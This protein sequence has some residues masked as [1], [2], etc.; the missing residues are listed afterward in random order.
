MSSTLFLV[1]QLRN[2]LLRMIT[3]ACVASAPKCPWVVCKSLQCFRCGLSKSYHVLLCS[4]WHFWIFYYKQYKL[5]FAAPFH[6]SETTNFLYFTV[7]SFSIYPG[8]IYSK[9]FVRYF[10]LWFRSC[11][12]FFAS[13]QKSRNNAVKYEF[14]S[15]NGTTQFMMLPDW[16][17]IP[18]WYITSNNGYLFLENCLFTTF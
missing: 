18:T 8:A 10:S 5:K 6:K 3:V 17:K 11:G 15:S 14:N 7:I 12:L 13:I 2:R 16:R 4:S 9:Y 1:S